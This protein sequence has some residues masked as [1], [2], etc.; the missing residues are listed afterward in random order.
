V[1]LFS[2]SDSGSESGSE[3][4]AVKVSGSIN[5]TKVCILQILLVWSENCVDLYVVIFSLRHDNV[6]SLIFLIIIERNGT[7]RKC[8][9]KEK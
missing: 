5:A 9:P 4:V 2:D 3:S 8:R 1:I 7:W 6:F